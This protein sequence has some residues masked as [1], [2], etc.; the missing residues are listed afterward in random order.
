M[1]H[2][3]IFC[4]A[5]LTT[6]GFG[7]S[8]ASALFDYESDASYNEKVCD[9]AVGVWEKHHSRA[10]TEL[11]E[12]RV[13]AVASQLD[14]TSYYTCSIDVYRDSKTTPVKFVLHMWF[15]DGK[16]AVSLNHMYYPTW[17][18]RESAWAEV[19]TTLDDNPDI[20]KIWKNA[21]KTPNKQMIVY[22]EKISKK[23]K[24]RPYPHRH[25][26]EALYVRV[27]PPKAK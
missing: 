20:E 22:V 6:W 17:A 13:P 14:T 1:K 15:K 3:L 8:S 9:Y 12:D 7:T 5:L 10:G 16:M 24:A 25:G 23:E 11:L 27:T 21:Y 19:I 26:I 4:L 2:H 18:S